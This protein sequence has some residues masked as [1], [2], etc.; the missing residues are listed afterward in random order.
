MD[1]RAF[2][3]TLTKAAAGFTILPAATTY[4]RRW[5]PVEILVNKNGDAYLVD[6]LKAIPLAPLLREH[7]EEHACY[8][9]CFQK[10]KFKEP[11]RSS[12]NV[13]SVPETL[14]LSPTWQ[15]EILGEFTQG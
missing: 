12:G 7:F 2:L 1:R 5:R 15:Q 8:G 9:G 13:L 11:D 4:A 10:L 3:E 6:L 14:D